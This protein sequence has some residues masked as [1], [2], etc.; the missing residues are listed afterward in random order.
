L[1]VLLF[2]LAVD[3]M[4]NVAPT[5]D[6]DRD[7]CSLPND[8][9]M[10]LEWLCSR[11]EPDSPQDPDTIVLADA[12]VDLRLVLPLVGLLYGLHL[13]HCGLPQDSEGHGRTH[14]QHVAGLAAIIFR[15]TD[16][17]GDQ[18]MNTFGIWYLLQS[19]H[20]GLKWML[21]PLLSPP[22]MTT[23]ASRCHR[24]ILNQILKGERGGDA[25]TFR[26][27]DKTEITEQD[28]RHAVNLRIEAPDY[29]DERD[30]S[31]PRQQ[32]RKRHEFAF[33]LLGLKEQ[34]QGRIVERLETDPERRVDIDASATSEPGAG[35]V[36]RLDGIECS[37]R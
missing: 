30:A 22:D 23:V 9:K 16:W 8:L 37:G 18:L 20:Y 33:G 17:E 34:L 28:F 13:E 11:G 10:A 19:I 4:W 35:L 6:R 25:W 2:D 14:D 5:N 12:K 15:F 32:H 3:M 26:V 24:G 31:E 21:L 36:V 27:D 7:Q 29:T 1:E